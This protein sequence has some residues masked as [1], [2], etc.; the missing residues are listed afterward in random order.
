MLI[1]NKIGGLSDLQGVLG[2]A[3]KPFVK[4]HIVDINTGFI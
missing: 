1:I 2:K 3:V 4:V